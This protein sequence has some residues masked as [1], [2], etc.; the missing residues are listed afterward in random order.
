[1]KRRVL[2]LGVLVLSVLN[3]YSQSN[4]MIDT[5]IA[6]KKAD[7]GKTALIILTG[8]GILEDSARPSEAVKYISENRWGFNRKTKDSPI[9]AGELAY[10]I[11][12]A[13]KL[14]GGLMYTFFPGPRY[15]YRELTF[16]G[17]LP[18]RGGPYRYVSGEEVVNTLSR[19]LNWK[20]GE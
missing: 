3:L 5:L 2:I 19:V 1:M 12:K 18:S 17:L 7:F 8:A 4:E 9:N 13:F 10:L 16:L 6:E 20:E 11:M 15:A 14:K